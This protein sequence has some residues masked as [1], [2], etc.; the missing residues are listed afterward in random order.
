MKKWNR[1]TINLSD[2]EHANL[3]LLA[4]IRKESVGKFIRYLLSIHLEAN[5]EL[6]PLMEKLKAA[7][8][9]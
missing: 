2:E 9:S 7:K 3:R 6:I 8:S 1:V 5:K 4:S